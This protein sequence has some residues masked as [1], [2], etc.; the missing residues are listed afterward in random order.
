MADLPILNAVEP[1]VIPAKT[2][3]RVWVEEVVIRAPDPNGDVVGEVKLH[4][5][6]MFDGVAELEPGNGQ[7]IRVENML[8]KS[9]EDADLQTA[10]SALLAYVGKIGVE[11]NV[12]A[13]P[14]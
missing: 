8:A 6:G 9:A 5:Y 7:W 4:K 11:N 3:D 14:A 10:M 2:Y 13:P 12:V 1:T